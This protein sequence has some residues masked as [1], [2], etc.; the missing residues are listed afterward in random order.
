MLPVRATVV[1]TS[2]APTTTAA[3]RIVEDV[4]WA[5]A[6]PEHGLEHVRAVP[7]RGRIALV[8]FVRADGPTTAHAL[9]ENLLARA[10]TAATAG[11]YAAA[12]HPH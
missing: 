12:V 11:R 4:L 1:D 2:G 6:T 9:A 10:L 8:L 3:A 5:H 7:D